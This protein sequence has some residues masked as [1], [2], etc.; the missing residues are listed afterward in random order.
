MTPE[1]QDLLNKA[2][3]KKLEYTAKMKEVN[4]L[5]NDAKRLGAKWQD[6]ASISVWSAVETVRDT[7]NV[8]LEEATKIVRD[9]LGVKIEA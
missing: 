6:Y 4:Q 1:V 5:I 9:Y 2:E 8:R 7:E 3:S